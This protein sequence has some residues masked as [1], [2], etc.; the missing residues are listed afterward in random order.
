MKIA[1]HHRPGSFS[2]YWITWCEKNH[3]PYKIV[4]AFSCNILSDVLEC[5]GFMWHWRHDLYAD[6]LLARQLIMTLQIIGKKVFPDI[7]TSWHYD[8]KV[9]QK[10]I[11][12][13]IGVDHVPTYIFF[14][15]KSAI[16]WLK[17]AEY[18]LVFKLKS[19]A[20]SENVKKINNFRHA[21]HIVNIAFK[22][23][24]PL[25]DAYAKSMQDL[26]IYKREKKIYLLIKAVYY[27]LRAVMGL[28][29]ENYNMFNREVGYVYF[30]KYI[31]DNE[32]D[33]RLIVIGEKCFCIQR[34]V[35]TGDFRAS[36]SGLLR[37]DKAL[38]PLDVVRAAFDIA[39]KVNTQTIALDFVYEESGK[40]LV[41]EMSYA[42]PCGGFAENCSGYY[43]SN[44]IWHDIKCLQ[45]ELMIEEFVMS[46]K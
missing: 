25:F 38:F 13:A 6:R 31:P 15:K 30:Q 27:Y 11:F 9:A 16:E 29:N 4:D 2:D 12:E 46:I 34:G 20:G 8:D 23:G 44:L 36:G 21:T 10:Y 37:Y 5:D 42:F 43:D 22:K 35:R 24:F 33:H 18:P 32:Y 40:P 7:N 14:T 28:K 45:P 39:Q 1:I 26:W 19:G 17:K 41:I 3:I